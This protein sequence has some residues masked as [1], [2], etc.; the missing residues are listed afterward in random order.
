MNAAKPKLGRGLDAL[1]GDLNGPANRLTIESIGHNPWQP[2]KRFDDDEL[3]Q[4]RDSIK[5]HGV[6][7]PLVVRKTN[8]GFQLIAGERRLRAAQAAGLKEVPV[9]VVEFNDQQVYE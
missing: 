9:H 8:A 2:R 6:L 7:Q 4:L 3:T 1:I 5:T